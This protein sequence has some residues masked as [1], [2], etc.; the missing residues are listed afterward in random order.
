MEFLVDEN[1]DRVLDLSPDNLHII[2]AIDGDWMDDYWSIHATRDIES[3]TLSNSDRIDRGNRLYYPISIIS[4]RLFHANH[5]GVPKPYESILDHSN[6]VQKDHLNII[7]MIRDLSS[8]RKST[9]KTSFIDI[10][11]V[12]IVF[13]TYSVKMRMIK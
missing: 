2:I 3:W 10:A 4:L 12:N 8:S 11:Y 7:I 13:T 9:I 1:F 5:P 6:T